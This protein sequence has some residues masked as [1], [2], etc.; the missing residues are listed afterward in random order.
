M[1]LHQEC[2]QREQQVL[3]KLI[4]RQLQLG[5]Q[6]HCVATLVCWWKIFDSVAHHAAPPVPK[7]TDRTLCTLAWKLVIL[8]VNFHHSSGKMLQLYLQKRKW[9]LS[10][11]FPIH[12]DPVT[13][14]EESVSLRKL[15]EAK[16][17]VNKAHVLEV[18]IEREFF[19]FLKLMYEVEV[20]MLETPV[21]QKF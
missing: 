13:E 16:E 5:S 18:C 15:L 17:T 3:A 9:Q 20:F 2:H 12:K 8:F 7:T 1:Y 4:Q 19:K 14:Y 11:K 6:Q 21:R 10:C